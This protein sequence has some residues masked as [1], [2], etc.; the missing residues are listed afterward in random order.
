M[1]TN[2]GTGKAKRGF[3]AMSPEKQREIASKGGKASHGGGRKPGSGR[4]R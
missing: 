2:S 3:A 1:A 4:A